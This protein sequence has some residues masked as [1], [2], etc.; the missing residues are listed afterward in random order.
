MELYLIR[1]GQTEFNKRN[2]VQG[3]GVD[4]SLND[5]GRAQ[6]NAF[7]QTYQTHKFDVVISS[8]LKRSQETIESFI[9]EGTPHIIKPELNEISWGDSEGQKS[10]TESVAL[11]KS[12]NKAWTEGDYNAR[13]P[14][15]E[16]AAELRDRI[17]LFKDWLIAQPYSKLLVC[18]HGRTMRC[19]M[20]VLQDI[21]VSQMSIF[22]HHNTGLY[23]LKFDGTKFN[24]LIQNQLDHLSKLD[25]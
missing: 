13:Y 7:Y 20:C 19:M 17:K 9:S 25:V 14:G 2:I 12:V 22:H 1:H 5:T 18:S 11:Y 4:T 10:T 23:I 15:G 16:S 6:A 24:M 8:A 21:P 3:S